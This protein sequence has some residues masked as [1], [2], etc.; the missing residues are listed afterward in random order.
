MVHGKEDTEAAAKKMPYQHLNM[1]SARNID[2]VYNSF[3][4][5]LSHDRH[6]FQQNFTIRSYELG[7]DGK[8]SLGSLMK[9]LQVTIYI[10]WFS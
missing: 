4:G 8:A 3:G 6:V 7:P 10:I 1:E 9:R 5:K 2:G